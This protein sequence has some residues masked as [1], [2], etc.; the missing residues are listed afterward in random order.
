MPQLQ[1]LILLTL[2]MEINP[3]H[4]PHPLIKADVIKP[5][6]TRAAYT[7]HA[8]IGN[9][10]VFLPPHEQVFAIEV[11][12]ERERGALFCGF[13]QRSPSG[14]ARPVLEVDLLGGVPRGMCGAEEV[15]GADDF[16]LEESC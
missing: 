11:V 4:T 7:L 6:E 3:A 16:A 12:F 14:E 2:S 5:L 15:F 13:R 9:E 10:E 1:L 8:M